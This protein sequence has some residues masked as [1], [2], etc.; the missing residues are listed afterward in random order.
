[1]DCTTNG[2]D[3]NPN[4]ASDAS[5]G[6]ANA[7]APAIRR[8]CAARS[9][10]PELILSSL[11]K[12]FTVVTKPFVRSETSLAKVASPTPEILLCGYS[13]A[14]CHRTGW[15]VTCCELACSEIVW[16]AAGAA[17]NGNA[18]AAAQGIEER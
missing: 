7:S 11:S 17:T 15:E 9:I 4:M 5:S 2:S 16:A 13:V 1:M 6:P 3:A 10:S 12:A 18:T 8:S 14:I